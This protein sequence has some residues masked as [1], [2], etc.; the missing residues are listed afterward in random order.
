ML[1]D[2]PDPP[3]GLLVPPPDPPSLSEP[4]GTALTP[5]PP[6][7]DVIV[8]KIELFPLPTPPLPTVIG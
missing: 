7:V 3:V 8:E 4:V 6:A 1:P 2:P 5:P